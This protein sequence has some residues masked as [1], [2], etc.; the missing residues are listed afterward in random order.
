M[1]DMHRRYRAIATALLQLYRPR[2]SGHRAR[3]SAT[4]IHLICGIV[5]AH[6]TQ[7][8]KILEHTPG[9][10]AV[11]ESVVKRFSR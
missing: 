7:L 10:K 1:R 6:H 8:P 5:G 3:H 4:L 9:G 2:P 11:D